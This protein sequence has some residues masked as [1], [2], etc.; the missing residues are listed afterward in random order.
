MNCYEYR[1]Q[2]AAQWF[3]STISLDGNAH[4][5]A[6]TARYSKSG[7]RVHGFFATDE[8]DDEDDKS[9]LDFAYGDRI[10][11]ISRQPNLFRPCKSAKVTTRKNVCFDEA[12]QGSLQHS[13]GGSPRLL[14]TPATRDRSPPETSRLSQTEYGL[15]GQAAN[16]SF[17]YAISTMSLRRP[18]LV[19]ASVIPLSRDPL[20][21]S[22]IPKGLN[23]TQSGGVGRQR[24]APETPGA[25]LNSLFRHTT[26][27]T[28]RSGSIGQD[29]NLANTS[30]PIA[31]PLSHIKPVDSVDRSYARFLVPRNSLQQSQNPHRRGRRRAETVGGD[32]LSTATGKSAPT[33]V[34]NSSRSVAPT[35]YGASD[36]GGGQYRSRSQTLSLSSMASPISKPENSPLQ[37]GTVS[38]NI[39]S[40]ELTP[41]PSSSENIESIQPV[42]YDDP[43]INYNPLLLDDPMAPRV[44]NRRVFPFQGYVASILGYRRADEQKKCLNREF[45]QRFPNVQ[46]TL[47]KMRS[48]KLNLLSI[49]LRMNL[50]LW[51]VAHAYV[52][53]EKMILKLFVCKSNRKLC[54]GAA[55]LIGAKLNDLKGPALPAFI[56]EIESELRISHRDLLKMEMAVFIGLEFCVLP[57]PAEA[58]PHFYQIQKSL[59]VVAVPRRLSNRSHSLEDE[60]FCSLME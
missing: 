22:G 52:L 35:D 2:I 51:I 36:S 17:R 50:D 41:Y 21:Q 47:T 18:P 46:L 49:A 54:A 10:S 11:S 31:K 20:M 6:R 27:N 34:T 4:G 7:Q 44:T 13:D 38:Y 16:G 33:P 12:F 19:M 60:H 43:L 26:N 53:F 58:Q 9:G 8:D 40:V 55:L 37:D 39:Q 25:L 3:L 32:E 5:L 28:T 57:S 42:V 59:G 24:S 15:F 45:H 29:E 56:Q 23:G 30:L 1:Q 14:S 48:L